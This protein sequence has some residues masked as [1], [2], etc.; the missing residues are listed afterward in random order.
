MLLLWPQLHTQLRPVLEH[1]KDPYLVFA[2]TVLS[3]WR[4][5]PQ[6]PRASLSHLLWTSAQMTPHPIGLPSPP[7]C[8]RTLTLLF[9]PYASLFSFILC[10]LTRCILYLCGY[11]II[12][13]LTSLE[14]KLHDKGGLVWFTTI[15]HWLACSR[16]LLNMYRREGMRDGGREGILNPQQSYGIRIVFRYWH[17]Y[18]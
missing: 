7:L 3:A 8:S 17:L 14:C 11:L 18:Q 16:C 6:H 10:I 12:T 9:P 4:L 13:C 1:A 15:S 5:F 2:L